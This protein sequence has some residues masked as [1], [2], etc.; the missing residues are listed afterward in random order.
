MGPNNDVVDGIRGV[1]LPT[2]HKN[3]DATH[4]NV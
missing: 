3:D 2:H 1:I 4:H